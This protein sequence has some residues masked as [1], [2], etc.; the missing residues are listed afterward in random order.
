MREINFFT[1]KIFCGTNIKPIVQTDE[2]MLMQLYDKTGEGTMTIHKIF[3]GAYLIYNDMHLREYM[4]DFRLKENTGLLCI[5]HCREGRMESEIAKGAYSYLQEHE[6][7]VDNR[8]HHDGH[9]SFPL[10]H[11]HGLSINFDL[12]TAIPVLRDL[13][14][15]FSVNLQGLLKKYCDTSRPYV[16]HNET[17][18]EHIMSELYYVPGQIKT[19]YYKIKALE[20]LLYLDALQLSDAIEERPYFYRGQVEKV[21]A[22][23]TF[24][25]GNLQAHYTME[26]LAQRFQISLTGMKNCFKEVYG[27]SMYSYFRRYRINVAATLLRQD[28]TK[29]VAE[30]GGLVGYE[31]PGKFSSAFRQIMGQTP[32]E[33]RNAVF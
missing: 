31:S 7:R 5:D 12:E 9:I 25:V 29:S 8:L 11:F 18:L 3:D 10:C 28:S 4:C 19:E 17:G 6:M 21:K 32:F 22:I 27:D 23:H 16:I 20:L 13:Y 1:D 30:I 2:C 26:E 14:G 24:I 33:Y 15:G